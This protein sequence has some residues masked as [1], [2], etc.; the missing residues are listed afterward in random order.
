MG[1]SGKTYR[2]PCDRGGLNYNQNIDLV[3]PEMF[4]TPSRNINLHQGG[5]G[6]R[7]GTSKV[8]SSAIAGTPRI[9][10]GFDFQLPGTSYQVFLGNNGSLYKDTSAT[11]KTGMSGTN[12]PSFDVFG[13]E[14]YVC[15]G[16]TTPQTWDGSAG[17]TSN[18]TTP[19]GD[20]STLN[21]PFQVIAHGRGASRRMWYLYGSAVYYSSLADGKVVSG[22]TSG[23][24]TINVPDGFGLVGGVEF[25]DRLIVFSRNKAYI[26]DDSS[27]DTADWGYEAAA[28]AGGVAHWRL[29]VKTPNDLILMNDEGEVY[30]ITAVQSYGDY[31]Q[32]SL[33]RPAFIDNYI[34]ENIKLSAID[35]FHASY[36]PEL[37]AIKFFVMR[38]GQSQIDTALVYFIDRP[39]QEGWAIHDNQSSASGYKASCSFPVRVSTGDNLIYTGDYS[40]FLWKLEQSQRADDGVG[41]YGGFRVPNLPFDNPRVKKHYKRGYVVI[42]TQGSYDLEVRIWVD[43]SEKTATSV[44]LSGTGGV[45]GTFVLGTDVL[46]GTEFAEKAFDLNHYGKRIQNEFYNDTASEDFFVSQILYDHKIMGALP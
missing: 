6:K 10:G 41:Y 28:W 13:S 32:A 15:D 9:L 14:L 20:W 44:S 38:N 2:V 46:S 43:G 29:I 4:V 22:G 36:D 7:G 40:G 30:S 37:R 19:S 42:R 5:R 27:T 12:K 45:L 39:P 31:K 25:Q 34:R 26:I 21:Q 17:S 33:A 8:N 16:D 23:K 11:I 24:I 35:D 18:I 3:P 1:Y